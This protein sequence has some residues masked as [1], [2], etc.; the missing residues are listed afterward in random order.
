[1]N[2]YNRDGLPASPFYVDDVAAKL[3]IAATAVTGGAISPAGTTTFLKRQTALYTITPDTGNYMLDLLVDGV[4]V[5]A[6]RQYTFDPLY[7]NHTIHATFT[8]A[9]P[10]HRINA[11]AGAGGSISPTGE[12]SV[13]QGG[14]Q[15]FTIAPNPGCLLSLAVDGQPMG[16]RGSFTFSDLSTSHSIAATFSCTIKASA[17]AGGKIVPSGTLTVPAGTNQTFTITPNSFYKISNV[18][19][20]G[21]S[22]GPLASY[23]FTN[24]S[25]PHTIGVGFALLPPTL[26]FAL[27]ASGSLEISWPDIYTGSLFWSPVVSPGAAWNPVAETPAHIGSL[28]KVTLAPGPGAIFYCLKQ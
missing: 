11:T 2:L 23:S 10:A 9:L 20:D 18:Q 21:V 24:V 27:N 28:Y 15:A 8:N 4:S 12:V 7:T 14:A 19:V 17:G 6:V 26:A 13:A 16:A 3:T 1:M 22:Q 5:G 25:A